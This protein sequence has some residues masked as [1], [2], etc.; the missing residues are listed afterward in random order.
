VTRTD[1]RAAA[2][3]RRFVAAAAAL[4]GAAACAAPRIEQRLGVSAADGRRVSF[5]SATAR[6][7]VD[8]V[9]VIHRPNYGTDVVAVNLYLLGG[10][11][12]LTPATQGVEALLVR[13]GEY[14]S[15]GYPGGEQRA[16]WGRTGSALA[17][18]ADADWT[19]YGFRGLG[20]EFDASW[21]VWADRLLRPALAES[22]LAV[23]RG[24]LVSRARRR[25]ADPDGLAFAAADSVAYAGHPYA[26]D[27]AG[28][29]A[30]LAALDS[31][32][33]RRYAEAQ[34]VRSRLLV[35]VVGNADR[36]RVEAAVR[37]SF[38]RL[39]QGTYAWTLPPA[40]PAAARDGGPAAATYLARP[41]ATNYVLGVF[42]GPPA[43]APDAPAFRVA[44]ALLGSRLHRAVREERG[45][46]YAAYA[47]FLDRGRTGAVLYMSTTLPR[48]ALAVARAQ[49]DTLR[50][51]PY[52]PGSMRYFTDQF[53][54]DHLAENMTSAAQADVLARAE[55]LEGDYRRGTHAMEALRGLTAIDVRA[56][57]ARYL[58]RPQFV[59]LGDTTRVARSAFREF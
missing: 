16:A 31:A 35:V 8:G 48:G 23:V 14:G 49:L 27:P 4:A 37:R 57:A 54:A 50:R 15:A 2:R 3:A 59:Y 22:S 43:S 47:P 7:D 51:L 53:V 34:L 41:F 29:E 42:Q 9:R 17:L 6:F 38:A 20:D 32:A 36:A 19:L 12:Q 56:A 25:R 46:S 33:V 30:S 52:P 58:R 13:A 45:L 24:R 11:R 21:D 1:P 39:P 18:S 26:L 55:L 40:P 10:T 44:A 28:T 5:D